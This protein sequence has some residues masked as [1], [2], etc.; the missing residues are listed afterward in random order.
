MPVKE[1]TAR[2]QAILKLWK[3]KVTYTEIMKE[4]NLKS[5][6][7]IWQIV[8]REKKRLGRT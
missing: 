6:G 5:K 3:N 7:N 8:A 1:K 2:N 4:F